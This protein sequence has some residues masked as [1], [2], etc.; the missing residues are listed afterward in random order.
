MNIGT[1]TNYQ[2]RIKYDTPTK[3]YDTNA[4]P[5]SVNAAYCT[6]TIETRVWFKTYRQ[7]VLNDQTFNGNGDAYDDQTGYSFGEYTMGATYPIGI[8]TAVDS[9]FNLTFLVYADL[10]NDRDFT[11]YNEVIGTSTPNGHTTNFSITIPTEDILVNRDLRMR[12]L[13]HEGGAFTTCFSPTGG[14]SESKRQKYEPK[15]LSK[16]ISAKCNY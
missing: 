8:T 13:G 12:I 2:F 4:F 3:S 1:T 10:N 14:H 6:P 11:D 16:S 15:N 7:V 9:W 5:F